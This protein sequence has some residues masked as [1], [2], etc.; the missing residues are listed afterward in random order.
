M[1]YS[2]LM[3]GIA[4]VVLYLA[5]T[6]LQASALSRNTPVATGVLRS[7]VVPALILHG[8]A[9]YGTMNLPEGI[10]LGLVS[11]ASLTALLVLVMVAVAGIARPVH[12]L[13]VLLF[14]LSALILLMSLFPQRGPPTFVGVSDALALHVLVSITA[15]SI[16]LMAALQ[17]ILVGMAERYIRTKSHILMLRILP[18]LETMEHLLFVML[19]VGFTGLTIAIASGFIQLDDMFAQRVAHHTILSSAA[20]VVYV[21]LLV[22]RSLFGWRGGAAARWTLV[23]F[24]LLLL[25]YFGSKFVLEI[26]LE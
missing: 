1:T 6:W 9:T 19:W 4:A 3:P 26:V 15:F 25:G 20:W 12:S 21:I 13:F 17:S 14:P 11:V 5:G 18:P 8:L 22:G 16:L 7:I 23:A 24:A 10:H 2:P